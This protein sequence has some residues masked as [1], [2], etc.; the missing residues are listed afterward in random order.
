VSLPDSGRQTCNGVPPV[1]IWWTHVCLRIDSEYFL[2]DLAFNSLN[3]YRIATDLACA[4]VF[5]DVGASFD[6]MVSIKNC[7]AEKNVSIIAEQRVWSYHLC[8]NDFVIQK[9]L[10]A[11][12][13]VHG[14]ARHR[15]DVNLPVW[16]I[17]LFD[18]IVWW[19]R[20]DVI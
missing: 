7:T 17:G 19:E 2:I 20:I 14:T 10:H 11:L 16:V 18:L 15:K 9:E 6:D 8:G 13:R 1:L 12:D 5:V 4:A 3:W